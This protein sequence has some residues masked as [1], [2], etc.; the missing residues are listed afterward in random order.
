M[1]EALEVLAEI[2]KLARLIQLEEEDLEYLEDVSSDTIRL[3]RDQ[4]AD[5]MFD[6]EDTGLNHLVNLSRILPPSLVAS[7]SQ[8]VVSP[9]LAARIAGFV[10]V[11]RA[12]AV[13]RRLPLEY[14]AEVAID[15]DPRRAS[16]VIGG[17]PEATV[18][19]VASELA[20]RGE[21]VAMGRFAAHLSDPMIAASFDVI[22]DDML[23][24][25]A[26]VLEE[27]SRLA[28]VMELL[29]D[30]RI[31]GVLRVAGE[32]GLWPQALDLVTHLS[33][34]QH[35]RLANIAAQLDEAIIESLIYAAHEDELWDV[36]LPMMRAMEPENL[37]RVAKLPAIF[38]K[39]I[40]NDLLVAA[41]RNKLWPDVIRLA[42]AIDD[43]GPLVTAFAKAD[44]EALQ[45]L[46]NYASVKKNQK[47]LSAVL[48][49]M[50]AT[51]R[52]QIRKRAEQLEV[53]G[54][55]S[56]LAQLLE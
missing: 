43:L 12:I 9:V 32:E 50:S 39:T 45:G 16:D 7:V 55:G 6:D 31:A 20:E 1:S 44:P 42:D 52:R 37:S 4:V 53:L 47:S 24:E 13:T 22:A 3:L 23:L 35:A 34:S 18:V 41:S 46:V 14:L 26:F 33:Q 36:V 54:E 29:P 40:V 27:K 10:E 38:E 30:E 56:P 49:R 8:K 2:T 5:L 48:D 19:R 25:I 21:A 17:M 15:I 28:S 11:D 51:S